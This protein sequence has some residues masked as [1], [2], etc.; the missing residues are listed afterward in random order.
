MG[1]WSCSIHST[2]TNELGDIVGNVE[3]ELGW[4]FHLR[5]CLAAQG[6]RPALPAR[7][8]PLHTLSMQHVVQR[9]KQL[10]RDDN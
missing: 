6:S 3:L 2:R 10:N 8:L 5:N 7:P 9:M 4:R 1:V